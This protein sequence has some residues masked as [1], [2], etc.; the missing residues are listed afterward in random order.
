MFPHSVFR[1]VPHDFFV[2]KKSAKFSRFFVSADEAF[3]TAVK[4]SLTTF[5]LSFAFFGMN[6]EKQFGSKLRIFFGMS[7][8]VIL[9]RGAATD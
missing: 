7:M 9:N 3:L 5:T 8:T 6:I 1:L 4:L 2:L